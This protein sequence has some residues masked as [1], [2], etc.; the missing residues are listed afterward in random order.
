MSQMRRRQCLMAISSTDSSVIPQKKGLILKMKETAIYL[1]LLQSIESSVIIEMSSWGSC[2]VAT[3]EGVSYEPG[4]DYE[5]ITGPYHFSERQFKEV[6][7]RI[8][9]GT[10]D[11]CPE[12]WDDDEWE[13]AVLMKKNGCCPNK[14]Y[15]KTL[16]N[17]A[18]GDL[19]YHD[20]LRSAEEEVLSFCW[21]N[22]SHPSIEKWEDMGHDSL[23]QWCKALKLI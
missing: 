5:C 10:Q 1:Q 20:S 7:A 13:E 18:W 9:D 8:K 19:K 15:Y 23:L 6:G 12:D 11:E 14:Q 2:T 4:G 22:S 17:G 16:T 21:E 3:N